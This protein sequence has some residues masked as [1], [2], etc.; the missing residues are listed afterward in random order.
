MPRN[1]QIPL[2]YHELQCLQGFNRYGIQFPSLL[3]G[4]DNTA[5]TYQH[6]LARECHTPLS[7]AEGRW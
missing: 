5:I 1:E 4:Y 3:A 7:S 6:A 2:G